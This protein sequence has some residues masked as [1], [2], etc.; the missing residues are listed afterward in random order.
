[1]FIPLLL[2]A[3]L[4]LAQTFSVFESAFG[5]DTISLLSRDDIPL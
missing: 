3:T 4:T 1:M 5:K 2:A